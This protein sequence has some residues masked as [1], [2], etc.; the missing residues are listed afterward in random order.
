MIEILAALIVAMLNLSVFSLLS[1]SLTSKVQKVVAKPDPGEWGWHGRKLKSKQTQAQNGEEWKV[2]CRE[3]WRGQTEDQERG[4]GGGA[5]IQAGRAGTAERWE[6]NTL[7]MC[8]EIAG[9]SHPEQEEA[10]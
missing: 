1:G 7:C 2:V 5:C 9:G 3:G 4:R 10:E 8:S 6:K